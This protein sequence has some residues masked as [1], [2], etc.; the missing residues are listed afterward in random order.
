M[1]GVVAR[2]LKIA[3]FGTF[4]ITVRERIEIQTNGWYIKFSASNRSR[5][6]FE[7]NFNCI[8][9]VLFR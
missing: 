5:N 9:K 8:S 4:L 2:D 1:K 7:W 6:N 3:K